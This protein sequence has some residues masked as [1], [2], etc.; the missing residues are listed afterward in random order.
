MWIVAAFYT[1]CAH[2]LR[3]RIVL[4]HVTVAAV[5][6]AVWRVEEYAAEAMTC[7]RCRGI[8]DANPV[9]ATNPNIPQPVAQILHPLTQHAAP[10]LTFAPPGVAQVG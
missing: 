2:T 9:S 6:L 3:D 4:M 5:C 10:P 1:P 8:T 7:C